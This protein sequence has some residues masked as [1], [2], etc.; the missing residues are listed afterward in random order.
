MN[1]LKGRIIE[2]Y[3]SYKAFSE[4]CGIPQ[5]Q[6]YNKLHGSRPFSEEQKDKIAQL[7]E[8]DRREIFDE[9]ENSTT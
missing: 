5:Y 4:A 3:G 8:I 6:L 2:R 7:L 9:R 1:R